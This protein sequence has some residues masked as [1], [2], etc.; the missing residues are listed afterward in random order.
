VFHSGRPAVA[1]LISFLIP[2]MAGASHRSD[3]VG[4]RSARSEAAVRASDDAWSE[5]EQRGD[6]Q[7]VD[8]LLLPDYRSVG[9]DGT[10]HTKADILGNTRRNGGSDQARKR[11]ADWKARH[12]TNTS[13]K[14]EGDTAILTFVSATNTEKRV[15]SCDVFVLTN[16]RWRALY[17]QHTTAEM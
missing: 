9:P 8:R 3:T 6:V 7:F 16:G 14:I 12:P 1:L 2:T 17:S 10:V 13:V 4:L 15:S 5:A 11:V